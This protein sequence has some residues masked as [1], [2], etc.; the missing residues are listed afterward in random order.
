MTLHCPNCGQ[1]ILKSQDNKILEKE[2]MLLSA[3]IRCACGYVGFVSTMKIDDNRR[4][5][6]LQV[7]KGKP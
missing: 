3:P 5:I 6:T 7:F 1:Q 4:V 2:D